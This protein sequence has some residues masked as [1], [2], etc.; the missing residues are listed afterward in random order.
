MNFI[1]DNHTAIPQERQQELEDV[2]RDYAYNELSDDELQDLLDQLTVNECN[3][4]LQIIARE[5]AIISV[6]IQEDR[7]I[8]GV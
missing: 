8:A 1:T 7:L 4:L 5:Q 2:I 6:Q 3:A